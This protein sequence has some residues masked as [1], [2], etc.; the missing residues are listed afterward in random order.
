MRAAI[1]PVVTLA[2]LQGE[3]TVVAGCGVVGGGVGDERDFFVDGGA[4][5]IEGERQQGQRHRRVE[6]GTGRDGIVEE[7]VV[8]G[9][10]E[11]EFAEDL[12]NAHRRPSIVGRNVT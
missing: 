6:D 7:H 1:N 11:I 8:G 4:R 5:G 10:L 9:A 2:V 3:F 12:K